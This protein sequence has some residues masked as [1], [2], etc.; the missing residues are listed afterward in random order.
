MSMRKSIHNKSLTLVLGLAL[1]GGVL[2]MA[3]PGSSRTDQVSFGVDWSGTWVGSIDTRSL[4]IDTFTVILKKEG[5]TFTGLVNDTMG[6]VEKDAAVAEVKLAG[7]E[8]SFSFKALYGT[9][10]WVMKISI[11]GDRI[12]GQ[13]MNKAVGEWGPFQGLVKK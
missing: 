9:A 4:G 8:I 6:L 13:L 7:R 3:A 1:I 5:S 11:E 12:S 10:D 2:V